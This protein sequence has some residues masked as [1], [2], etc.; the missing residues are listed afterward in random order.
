MSRSFLCCSLFAVL[1]LACKGEQPLPM[2]EEAVV[3]LLVDV[4]IAEA[5]TNNLQG[6]LKDSVIVAYYEQLFK[7]HDIT[8]EEFDALYQLLENNPEQYLQI[9]EKVINEIGRMEV[10]NT[11]GD[12]KKG[13]KPTQKPLP[14][15]KK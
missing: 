13:E 9:Y 2:E 5:A 14:G 3:K 8:A 4:H 7:I 10:E 1:L 11:G 15:S 12:D 6:S